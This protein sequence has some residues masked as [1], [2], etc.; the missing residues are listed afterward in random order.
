MQIAYLRSSNDTATTLTLSGV[1][2][3]HIARTI[4]NKRAQV[5]T[6]ISKGVG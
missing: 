4:Y 6:T 5:Q 3:T 1:P 2:L